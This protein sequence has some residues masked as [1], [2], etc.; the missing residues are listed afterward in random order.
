LEVEFAVSA[1]V[2]GSQFDALNP[3]KVITAEATT[4]LNSNL[5]FNLGLKPNKNGR[6]F[7]EVMLDLRSRS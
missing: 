5:I 3:N 7:L 4:N 6:R 1:R 2:I